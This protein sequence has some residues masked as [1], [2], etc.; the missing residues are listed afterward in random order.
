MYKLILSF[1]YL[2]K[3][4][5]SYLTVLAVTLCV[6]VVLVVITVLTGLTAEFK[7]NAHRSTGDCVIT[8]KSM[9]GFPYS[10]EFIDTL[11]QTDFVEAASPVIKSYAFVNV[12][13]G[14]RKYGGWAIQIMGIDP[15]VHSRVTAFADWLH[16]NKADAANA[17][18]LGDFPDLIGCV[19][20]AYLIRDEWKNNYNTA[21][22]QSLLKFEISCFP[23]TAKG[24]LAK[25]GAG[26]VNTKTFYYTDYAKSGIVKDDGGIIYVPFADARILCGMDAEPKRVNAIYIKFK[27]HTNLNA[28]C[29]KVKQLWAGLVKRKAG[30]RHADLLKKVKVQNWKIYSRIIVAAMETEQTMMTVVFGLIGII[31]VFIVFVVFYMIVCHKSKDIGILKSLGVSTANVLSLFL[32][33]AFLIGIIGSAIGALAGWRFLVH[34]NLIEDWLF[35]HFGFQLWNRDI[36][37]IGDIPNSISIKVL[38]VIVLSAIVVCMAGA[39]IPSLQ[40]S[41]ARPIESLQ[42]NQL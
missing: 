2:F 27:P 33:F 25:A 34:I 4:P 8:S 10:Q 41:R 23:L 20:G 24:A 5:T 9:V 37:A 32:S 7:K 21:D 3:R 19:P 29:D 1:R 15:E 30:D 31:T 22:Q 35:K 18:K 36:Y 42:V 14:G 17:F 40:A 26:E 11:K 13:Q 39:L 6:F 38:A 28:G 12:E 16:F